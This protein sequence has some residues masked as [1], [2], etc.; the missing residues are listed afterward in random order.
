MDIMNKNKLPLQSDAT[1]EYD[2]PFERLIPVGQFLFWMLALA[3]ALFMAD[4][5]ASFSQIVQA[6]I[7]DEGIAHVA[8][9]TH[10][11]SQSQL[12]ELKKQLQQADSIK[13]NAAYK[14]LEN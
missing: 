3:F 5:K 10:E 4:I 7:K 2:R 12:A 1:M 14:V 6:P 11:L 13:L 9:I 8:V